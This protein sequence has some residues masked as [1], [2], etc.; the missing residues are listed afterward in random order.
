MVDLRL[1]IA[2]V[3]G[4][5]LSSIIIISSVLVIFNNDTVDTNSS[6]N[7]HNNLP[8]TENE[9]THSYSNSYNVVNVTG[10]GVVTSKPDIV[11]INLGIEVIAK[12]VKNANKEAS[13]AMSRLIKVVDKYGIEDDDIKTS[14]FNIA[15]QYNYRNESG[16]EITGFRVTNSIIVKFRDLDNI[17]FFIDDAVLSGGNNI[18]IN[19]INFSV[20][21][22]DNFFD[23]A[24]KSAIEN[25]RKKAEIFADAANIELGS[26]VHISESST[27]GHPMPRMSLEMAAPSSFSST[28]IS[29]GEQDI[30]V[31][32]SVTFSIR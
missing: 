5:T 26:V 22:S 16:P 31:Q 29:P 14:R 20:E 28:P 4:I 13:L 12:T 32:V 17:G 27:L 1:S 25:A 24:R 9:S 11:E 8:I 10:V 23:R 19:N 6:L 3:I 7:D 30:S 15:P 2:V 21:N 18:R